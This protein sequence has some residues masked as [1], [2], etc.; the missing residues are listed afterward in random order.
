MSE[1]NNSK[2]YQNNSVKNKYNK[3]PMIDFINDLTNNN[4]KK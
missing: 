3:D 1:S 4:K 2:K